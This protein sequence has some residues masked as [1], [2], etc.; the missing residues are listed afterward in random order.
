MAWLPDQTGNG[1]LNTMCSTKKLS[2]L[3]VRQTSPQAA[4]W[5]ARMHVG[6]LV[7]RAA[8]GKNGV[9]VAKR[10]GDGKTPAGRFQLRQGW[11][12]GDRMLRLCCTPGLKLLRSNLGW[13]D[14]RGSRLYN[15]PI[16]SGDRLR[17]E[18][19]WRDDAIYDVVFVTSHNERPRIQG[20]GSAIFFH[21]ARSDYS[22]TEGCIAISK[23]DMRRLLPRL[24]RK[25]LLEIKT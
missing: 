20:A 10:E 4:P 12:R 24:G 22:G 3:I 8:I 5:A 19:L 1:K 25:V 2:R 9:S 16:A 11:F 21:L 6:S 13:C 18:N 14:Q 17:H 23:D 7:I 15:R